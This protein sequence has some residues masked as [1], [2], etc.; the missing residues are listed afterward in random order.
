MLKN[1]NQFSLDI[2]DTSVAIIDSAVSI[3]DMGINKNKTN[4]VGINKNK[5]N[6]I[7]ITA[8]LI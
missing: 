8:G 5:T 2:G 3:H 7:F 1:N 6:D 4:D